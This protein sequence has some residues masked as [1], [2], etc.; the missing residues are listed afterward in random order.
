MSLVNESKWYRRIG[1]PCDSAETV[2]W[3][4]HAGGGA[5]PLIRAARSSP[6]RVNLFVATLPGREG[7]FLEPMPETLDE[8]TSILVREMPVLEKP[9]VLI[10]HSFGGL[11]AYRVAQSFR[12]RSILVMAMTSPDRIAG[13]APITHLEDREFAEKLDQRYGGVPKTLRENDEAMRLFLPTVRHDLS[14]LESYRQTAGETV[15]IPITAL[16]GTEDG[17]VTA[18]AMQGW[19]ERTSNR[20]QMQIWR[21]DHFFPIGQFERVL[22]TAQSMFL[23]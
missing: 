10:G 20:F 21:G 6:P 1:F 9:P 4:P 16:V 13:N 19:S 5:A 14:L 3:F 8:L 18:A 23:T 15:D 12:G 11:L 7:R 17:R 2:I 22:Q